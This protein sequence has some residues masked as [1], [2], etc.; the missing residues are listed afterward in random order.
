[1]IGTQGLNLYRKDAFE[2]F[3]VVR[4][5]FLFLQPVYFLELALGQFSSADNVG[6]WDMV[7]ASKGLL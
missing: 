2:S 3:T 6:V 4:L 1:M 5:F 7:P